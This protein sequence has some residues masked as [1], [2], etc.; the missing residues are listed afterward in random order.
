MVTSLNEADFSVKDLSA[1]YRLRWGIEIQFRAWKQS[2]DIEAA[3]NRHSSEN[4][5][6]ALMLGAMIAQVLA[7]IVSRCLSRKIGPERLSFEKLAVAI[8]TYLVSANRM[9]DLVN[10]QVDLRHIKRDERK[11]PTPLKQGLSTLA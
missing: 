9:D 2:I 8:N 4:H 10:F 6:T 7:M 11:A 1:I 3:L 5:M